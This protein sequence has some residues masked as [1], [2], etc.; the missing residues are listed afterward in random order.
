MRYVETD[1]ANYF[2]FENR[3][4]IVKVHVEFSARKKVGG[5]DDLLAR[6]LGKKKSQSLRVLDLTA[7]LGRDAYHMALIGCEV[8]AIERNITLVE[9][10][11]RAWRSKSR[12]EM[13]SFEHSDASDY[14]RHL[15]NA[16]DV[17]YYDPMFPEKKKS[18]LAGKESQLLQLLSPLTENAESEEG[19]ILAAAIEKTGS[20][21]VVKRPPGAPAILRRPDIEFKGKSI[22]YDVYIKQKK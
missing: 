18:A 21:V 14:L 10:L 9:A 4:Q 19:A 15:K 17:I 16:P 13:L 1:G 3:G 22:R 8:L 5:R 11:Q 7:G 12:A 20:R 2:E 6:A